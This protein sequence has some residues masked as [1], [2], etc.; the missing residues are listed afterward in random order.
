MAVNN[1][2]EATAQVIAEGIE[3]MEILYGVDVVYADG[4]ANQY[5]VASSVTDWAKVVSARVTL[6]VNS[7]ENVYFT[8]QHE[9]ESCNT[10]NPTASTLM[11]GEFNTTVRF[12]NTTGN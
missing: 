12:R 11:R 8:T 3:D 7:V 4:V 10:F 2:D 9:C 5:V 6:L 1:R